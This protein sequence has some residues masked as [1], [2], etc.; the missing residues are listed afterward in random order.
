SVERFLS[1]T[2][3]SPKKTGQQST[4]DRSAL[5]REY[6]EG[7]GVKLQD[8]EHNQVVRCFFHG[9]DRTPSASVRLGEGLF[10]CF[11]CGLAGDV[12]ELIMKVEGL[13]FVEAVAFADEHL[14]GG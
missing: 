7:K 4:S 3:R 13:N 12:Y 1:S 10:N 5:M 9:A 11:T 14:D 2:R 6:I 8:I